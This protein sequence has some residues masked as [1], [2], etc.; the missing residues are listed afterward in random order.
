[1]TQRSF[2]MRD[3]VAPAPSPT[4]SPAP[5]PPSSPPPSPAP[6]P[7]PSPPRERRVILIRRGTC[8]ATQE[9]PAA[10]AAGSIA[11]VLALVAL[12][13]CDSEPSAPPPGPDRPQHLPTATIGVGQVSLVVEVADEDAER[14]KGMMFRR[15]LADDEAML[16]VFEREANVH[17]WMKNTPADLDIA[18]IASDGTVAQIERLTAHNLDSVYSREPVRFALEVPAGW[19]ARHGVEVGTKVAIPPEVATPADP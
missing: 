15:R 14:Q 12:A 18:Y 7:P 11:L 16:F 9:C 6:S 17:F 8:Q 10:P 5:S 1:M 4:P 13:G 2:A 3:A 19:F